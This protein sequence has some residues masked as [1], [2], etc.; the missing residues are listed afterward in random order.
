MLFEAFNRFII[1]QSTNDATWRFWKDFI[2]TDFTAYLAL[3]VAIRTRHWTLR[4]A[5]LKEMAPTFWAFD[6]T[7]YC[8]LIPD[9]ISDL[10]T[11]PPEVL[12]SFML[13]C[14]SV[15]LERKKKV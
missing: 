13:C 2:F 1:K 15:G 9:H 4:M 3:Y 11:F 7:T 14:F 5:G 10:K 12:H 6:R 8:K